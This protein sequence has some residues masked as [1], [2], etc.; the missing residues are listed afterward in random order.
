MLVGERMVLSDGATEHE[1]RNEISGSVALTDDVP[2]DLLR[3]KIVIRRVFVEGSDD[4][5]TVYPAFLRY[6][7]LPEPLVSAQRITSNQCCAQRSPRCG[8]SR[9]FLQAQVGSLCIRLAGLLELIDALGF[10]WSPVSTTDANESM[11]QV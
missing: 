10:R 7:L 5:I 1:D 9:S 4:V 6:M 3:Q 2:C 8:D 11:W